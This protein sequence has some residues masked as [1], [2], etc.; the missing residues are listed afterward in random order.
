ML[1]SEVSMTKDALETPIEVVP[2]HTQTI[3]AADV[4]KSVPSV[5]PISQ[6]N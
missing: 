2:S 3:A 1:E 4:E 6:I 5:A